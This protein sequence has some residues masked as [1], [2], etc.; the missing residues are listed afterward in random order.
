MEIQS[1]YYAFRFH[2]SDFDFEVLHNIEYTFFIASC[3]IKNIMVL[4]FY[5]SK[6]IALSHFD[7]SLHF[8]I[9]SFELCFFL[10]VSG[11]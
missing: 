11:C 3:Q 8:I 9:T 6:L 7:F 5:G 2:F 1:L 10:G 4:E